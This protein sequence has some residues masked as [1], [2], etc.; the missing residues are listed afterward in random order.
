LIN[1]FSAQFE[2]EITTQRTMDIKDQSAQC[3]S[4]SA[5]RRNWL[6]MY[7]NMITPALFGLNEDLHLPDVKKFVK[8][9]EEGRYTDILAQVPGE[10][11]TCKLLAVAT[12]M[13]VIH[14]TCSDTVAALRSVIFTDESF[15]RL[16]ENLRTTTGAESFRDVTREVDIFYLARVMHLHLCLTHRPGLTPYDYLLLQINSNGIFIREIFTSLRTYLKRCPNSNIS[17]LLDKLLSR[18]NHRIALVIDEINVATIIS[19]E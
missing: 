16:I 2:N 4:F 19:K 11:K 3:K 1:E 14:I 13:F 10:G 15:Q 5:L 18:K 17:G 6:P 7:S 12:K 9:I 8:S